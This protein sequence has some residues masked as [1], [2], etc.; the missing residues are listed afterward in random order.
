MSKK[1]NWSPLVRTQ[2]ALDHHARK[3]KPIADTLLYALA[4]SG[5]AYRFNTMLGGPNSWYIDVMTD[6]GKRRFH[7]RSRQHPWRI[8]V[9]LHPHRDPVIAR[10]ESQRDVLRFV[11]RLVDE[12][13]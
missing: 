12:T 11:T 3:L 1:R 7:L 5:L 9:K 2:F 4:G 6:K 13:L 8:D 10:L